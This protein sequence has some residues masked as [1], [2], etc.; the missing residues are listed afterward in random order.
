M[1]NS[2]YKPAI[3]GIQCDAIARSGKRCRKK[4]HWEIPCVAVY[5]ARCTSYRADEFKPVRLCRCHAIL[6]SRL[7][8]KGQR[9]KLH[10]GGWLGAYNSHKFGNLVIDRPTINWGKVKKLRVPKFWKDES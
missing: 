4:N 7:Q 1:N 5:D 3:F 10:H 8:A 2:N 6:S 9:L